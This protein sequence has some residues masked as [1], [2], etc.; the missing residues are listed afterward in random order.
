MSHPFV[1]EKID[2]FPLVAI[3]RGLTPPEAIGIGN[4]LFEAGI[5]VMEVPLNSPVEPLESIRLLAGHFN[6]R[7]A[8]GAGT[9]LTPED[10]GHVQ[11]AGGQLVVSPNMNPAVI[12]RTVELG[13]HSVPGVATCTE[14]FTA[15]EAGAD[16]LKIFPAS[17]LGP[18]GI[19]DL[20]AVIP[21]E[22]DLFAVGGV[23]DENMGE[24]LATGVKGVG[25]GSNLYQ[26]GD[27]PAD[28][29]RKAQLMVGAFQKARGA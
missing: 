2:E 12:R 4:A 13:L 9:V 3:L 18:K 27:T 5:R 26:P 20:T 28:V 8:V 11:A 10:A 7:A 16:G 23:T 25:L 15:L 1:R 6:G 22:V 29:A 14:C 17:V 24:W 21:K 19:K